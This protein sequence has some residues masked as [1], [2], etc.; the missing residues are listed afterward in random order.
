MPSHSRILVVTSHP[1]LP[2]NT[3]GRQRSSNLLRALARIMPTDLVLVHD[4]ERLDRAVCQQLSDEFNMVACL[5]PTPRAGHGAWS[6]LRAIAPRAADR[7]AHNLGRR[8]F[9]YSADPAIAEP[10]RALLDTGRYAAAVGRYLIPA[11]KAS[12]TGQVPT[13]LDIDDLDTSVYRSRLKAPN[14]GCFERAVLRHHLHQ[15]DTI[16]PASL[17]PFNHLWVA[18]EADLGLVSHP[19]VST[20]PNIPYSADGRLPDPVPDHAGEPVVMV[21]GSWDHLPNISGLNRFLNESWPRVLAR[22]PG[23][24]LRVV[25]SGLTER[26]RSEW[27]ARPNVDVVGRVA[28]LREA[29]A[30]CTICVSPVFDGGGTKIKVLEALGFGRACVATSHSHRGYERTLPAGEAVAVGF[31]DEQLADECVR[32]LLDERARWSMARTGN[33]LVHEHY[34]FDGFCREVAAT[35]GRVLPLAPRRPKVAAAFA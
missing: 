5:A 2:A 10:V 7:L 8:S 24:R 27:S 32:L 3:G 28:D 11:A 16:V 13:I 30:G 12:I 22:V 4:P 1:P 19:S 23:A 31:T 6:G 33:L 20:L 35:I 34:S 25:G 9:D 14:A 26:Q 18:S 15:L 21:I 17:R 29:Y